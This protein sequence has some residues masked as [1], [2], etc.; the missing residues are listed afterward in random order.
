M[1]VPSPDEGAPPV[2]QLSIDSQAAMA[3]LGGT[4]QDGVVHELALAL[5]VPQTPQAAE[6]YPAWHRSAMAL[7]EDMDA[8][9]V[10][11]QGRP[12]TL[13][14]FA[15]IAGDLQ[16]LY[17]QLEALDLAAGSPAARRLFS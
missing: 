14:S 12:L 13:Q 10:D 7:A 9:V 1:V 8:S 6:P 11:D 15:A 5:D 3:A 4:P 16:Q 17:A 2:L